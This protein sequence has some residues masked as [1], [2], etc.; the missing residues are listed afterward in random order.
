MPIYEFQCSKCNKSEEHYLSLKELENFHPVCCNCSKPLE[1]KLS[2]Y[3]F[4]F[5]DFRPHKKEKQ[6]IVPINLIE[7]NP[8]GS[9]KVTSTA[10][11]P[12]PLNE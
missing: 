12:E 2:L 8:D 1:K 7:S 3:N 5:K 10:K 9:F 11:E 4:R 6:P